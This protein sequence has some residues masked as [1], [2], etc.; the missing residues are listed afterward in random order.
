MSFR[1]VQLGNYVVTRR[2][3]SYLKTNLSKLIC[4]V[5][6]LLS[7]MSEL[8]WLVRASLRRPGKFFS[9]ARGTYRD[10]VRKNSL[11]LRFAGK[12]VQY[13]IPPYTKQEIV[14][15]VI[16]DL[17]HRGVIVKDLDANKEEFEDFFQKAD[18]HQFK[19]YYDGGKVSIIHEKAFE[20]YLA[21]KLLEL[22]HEDIYIDVA[23]GDSPAPWIYQKLYKTRSYAHDRYF[24]RS[25]GNHISGDA[26]KIDVPSS[27][28]DKIALHCSFDHFVKNYDSKFIIEVERILKTNGKCCILPLYLFPRVGAV[29]DPGYV[30][31]WSIFEEFENIYIDY[32]F[33]NDFSRFYNGKTFVDRILKFLPENLA[34]DLIHIRNMEQVCPQC[35][36]KFALL[37]TKK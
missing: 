35:Y 10:K 11:E 19:Y 33:K 12:T 31:D 26:D 4:I 23:N 9:V 24:K 20:H 5:S 1:D 15:E 3:C 6:D 28:A 14:E 27:F 25:R 13:S 17:N 16:Q 22:S 29:T 30:S 7:L 8:T 18:Y 2:S 36:V 37:L 21:A 32:N 34:Y